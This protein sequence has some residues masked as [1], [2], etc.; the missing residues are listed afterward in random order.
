MK[1]RESS[2]KKLIGK[3]KKWRNGIKNEDKIKKQVM[4]ELAEMRQ[5]IAELEA[6]ETRRKQ[7]EEKLRESDAKYS[8]LVESSKDGIIIIQDGVLKFVNTASMELVGYT[9]E[10]MLDADFLNFVVPGYWELVLRRY[11]DRMAGKKVPSVYEIELFRKG[12]TTLPVEL[13]TVRINFHGKP[14]DLVFIRDITDRKRMEEELI[15]LANAVRMSTD[16]IV[17][18]DIKGK[19]IDVNEATLK[20]YGTEDKG[21]LIGKN[22]FDLIVPEERE[23]ALEN[24]KKVLKG[25]VRDRSRVSYYYQGRQ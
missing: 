19:I 24:L 21:D 25:G 22:S 20:M 23:K 7:A 5:R 8:T 11:T 9:P 6:S 2:I 14:A 17:I 15:R 18:S 10:E 1:G 16:S 13:N 3:S 12:G 4:N